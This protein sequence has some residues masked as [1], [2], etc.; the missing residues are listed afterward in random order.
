MQNCSDPEWK[1]PLLLVAK[2][3][4]LRFN[5]NNLTVSQLKVI[6]TQ[7]VRPALALLA[8]LVMI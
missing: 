3:G 6:V 4:S 7:S 2:N 8:S 1:W 5:T